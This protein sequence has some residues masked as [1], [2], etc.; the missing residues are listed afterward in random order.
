MVTKDEFE[1]LKNI[2]YSEKEARLANNCFRSFM[3]KQISSMVPGWK[4]Y[5]KPNETLELHRKQ[6][7]SVHKNVKISSTIMEYEK[8]HIKFAKIRNVKSP[9]RGSAG[10]AGIDF[11]I[12]EDFIERTLRPGEDVLIPSGIKVLIPHNHA[13]IAYNKSGV[14]TKKHLIVG[15][16]VIDEDYTGEIHLH[17]INVGKT[18]V[19]LQPGDK[20][21]QFVVQQMYYSPV[22]EIS[23]VEELY[24]NF[25]TTRG[26]GGFG[27]TGNK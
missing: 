23:S 16:C 24:K 9:S 10:S 4:K 5:R 21:V 27:S 11:F 13:L 14:A 19:I 12:P 25:K 18:A 15:A 7:N 22:N 20:I 17:M 3:M 1:V 2:F 8:N 6:E 26:S